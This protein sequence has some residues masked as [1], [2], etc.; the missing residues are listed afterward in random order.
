MKFIDQ[1]LQQLAYSITSGEY[2]WTDHDKVAI[3]ETPADEKGW[4]SIFISVNAFLNTN[5]GAL[6]VGITD[7]ESTGSYTFQ[8]VGADELL[9]LKGINAAFTDHAGKPTDLEANLSIERHHFS[10]GYVAS[11]SVQPL[12]EEQKFVFYNGSAWKRLLTGD[13]KMGMTI[14]REEEPP[15][16]EA[17]EQESGLIAAEPSL[18]DEKVL[19]QR[20]YSAELISLFGS[21]YIS[22]EP[23]YKQMLSYIY[24]RNHLEQPIYPLLMDICSDLWVIRGEVNAPNAFELYQLQV[25]KILASMEKTG[26]VA[27]YKGKQGYKVNTTYE[28]VKNLF[29]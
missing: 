15:V 14:S 6:I 17:A 1:L 10:G 21:D 5:G 13:Q 19:L 28:V 29:N 26:F 11:I 20:I 23:D 22:L 16:I 25:K 4:D 7:D 9:V 12:H 18:Q 2:I 3:K 24:E 8:G 27:R